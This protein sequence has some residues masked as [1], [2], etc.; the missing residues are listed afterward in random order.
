MPETQSNHWLSSKTNKD[1][2]VFFCDAIFAIAITLLILQIDVPEIVYENN[3][4]QVLVNLWPRFISFAISFF[5]IA[6]FW[7]VHLNFFSH[8]R[9]LNMGLVVMNLFFMALIVFLPFTTDF[10]GAHSDNKYVLAF[11]VLSIVATSLTSY[12]TWRYLL[13]HKELMIEDYEMRDMRKHSWRGL[14]VSMEFLT[15]L[16]IVFVHPRLEPWYWAIFVG[17][18]FVVVI[19]SRIL[20]SKKKNATVEVDNN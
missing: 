9:K 14:M 10:Y 5:V 17:I 2:F 7:L 19:G 1:R 3:V 20:N 15:A 16:L 8:V 4:H 13:R 11:Y 12:A 6:R 18:V